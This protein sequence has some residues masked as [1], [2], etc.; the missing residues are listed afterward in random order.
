M[1]GKEVAAHIHFLKKNTAEY[2]TV[3]VCVAYK[4]TQW[5]IIQPYIY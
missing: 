1:N 5:D 4:H 3:S 2:S